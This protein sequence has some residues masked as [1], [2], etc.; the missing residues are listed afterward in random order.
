MRSDNEIEL[1]EDVVE[2]RWLDVLNSIEANKAYSLAPW[3]PLPEE[4]RLAFMSFS[5]YRDS[6]Q[7]DV[8]L[9]ASVMAMTYSD[10][11]DLAN[12]FQ[13][14]RR[15]ECYDEWCD[16]QADT[17]RAEL[18]Q[19]TQ[20]DTAAAFS[21]LPSLASSAFQLVE[22]AVNEKLAAQAKRV[23]SG[24]VY[25]SNGDEDD[26]D[27]KPISISQAIRIAETTRALLDATT[28]FLGVKITVDHNVSGH[29]DHVH[30]VSDMD[31]IKFLDGLN[32]AGY[33]LPDYSDLHP[34]AIEVGSGSA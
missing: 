11:K 2:R 32:E 6:Q 12:L 19:R 22:S 16:R 17:A 23:K 28:R 4:S 13:W 26:E 27:M 3:Q 25:S 30:S 24:H 31:A 8:A 34:A 9:T 29:V 1:A 15:A 5:S 14:V 20:M 33:S 7:R 18:I 21:R 10:M